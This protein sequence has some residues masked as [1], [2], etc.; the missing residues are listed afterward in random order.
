MNRLAYRSFVILSIIL[1]APA[2]IRAAA[3]TPSPAPTAAPPESAAEKQFV[4]SVTADLQS[5]FATTAQASAGGYFQYTVEDQ[6]GAISWVNTNYWQSDPQHP[7]QLWYDVKGRLI[8][9]DFSALQSGKNTPRPTVWGVSASRWLDF[10]PAHVHFAIK[11][12]SGLQY[13]GVG[14][15]TMAMVGGSVENPTSA[16]I[17]KISKLKRWTRLGIPAPQSAADVAFVFKFPAL[18]DLQVWLVPN[19]LGAFAE[20]NPNVTPSASAKEQD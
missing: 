14:N 10:S 7:S 6:T 20:H 3:P 17:V 19:P 2:G 5:R 12:P 9:A 1:M 4:S 15:K 18:W 16:D 11:T 8:G 13:G